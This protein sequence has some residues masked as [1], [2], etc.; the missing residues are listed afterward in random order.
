MPVRLWA[1]AE[2]SGLSRWGTVNPGVKPVL[3]LHAPTSPDRLRGQLAR[4]WA[5]G[6]RTREMYSTR[7]MVKTRA[8]FEAGVH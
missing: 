1:P 5:S 6:C 3:G 4:W 7:L 2:C 8:T